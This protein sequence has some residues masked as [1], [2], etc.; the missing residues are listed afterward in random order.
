MGDNAALIRTEGVEKV[1]SEYPGIN[2]V[3]KQSA[4]WIT[5]LASSIVEHWIDS[6]KKFD[7]IA[8]NNDEMAIGAIRALKKHEKLEEVIVVGIDATDEALNEIKNGRLKATVFQDSKSQAREALD[9]AFKVSTGITVPEK[10]WI[11]F[12]LVTSKNYQEFIR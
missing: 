1:A 5:P 4:K 3:D 9:I 7:A 8:A 2:I 10:T 12:K 11:P 6:G